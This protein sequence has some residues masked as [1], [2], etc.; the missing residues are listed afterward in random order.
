MRMITRGEGGSSTSAWKGGNPALEAPWL[1]FRRVRGQLFVTPWGVVG[2]FVGT[3]LRVPRPVSWRGRRNPGRRSRGSWRSSGGVGWGGRRGEGWNLDDPANFLKCH[4]LAIVSLKSRSYNSTFPLFFHE[5]LSL[6]IVVILT[7][8]LIS[9]SIEVSIPPEEEALASK[10]CGIN[11]FNVRLFV[12]LLRCP[13]QQK[14]TTK[15][16]YDYDY[17]DDHRLAYKWT[18]CSGNTN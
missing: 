15:D 16:K 11:I 18:S 7:S 5:W 6:F 1:R 3:T 8:W 17:D 12:C 10:A 4:H 2:Q 13:K 14:T 9:L